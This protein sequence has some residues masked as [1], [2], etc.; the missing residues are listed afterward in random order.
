MLAKDRTYDLDELTAN[1]MDPIADPTHRPSATNRGIVEPPRRRLPADAA[2]LDARLRAIPTSAY[3]LRLS[4]H[5]ANRKGKVVC[6]FH[7]DRTPSLQCYPNGTWCCFG[8][9]R[10]G[11]IYDFAAALWGLDTT[12][13]EFLTLRTRLSDAFNLANQRPGPARDARDSRQVTAGLSWRE[14]T[15]RA[16]ADTPSTNRGGR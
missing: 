13:R 15:T 4:G 12:G 11:S 14:R 10:G 6:P 9:N 3:V 7:D 2:E 5:Q 16:T 1:L 8:C